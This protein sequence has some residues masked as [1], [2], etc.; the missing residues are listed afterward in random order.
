M[1]SDVVLFCFQSRRHKFDSGLVTCK[2][3]KESLTNEAQ[4]RFDGWMD[5]WM[6]ILRFYI[7]FNGISVISGRCAND[8]ER[9]CAMEHRLRLRRFRVEQGSTSG[10]LDQ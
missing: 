9:Q 7:L 6:D 3:I 1:Y 10:P 2:I 5:G 8:N 4:R